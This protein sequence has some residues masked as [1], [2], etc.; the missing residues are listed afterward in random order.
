MHPIEQKEGG[1][2]NHMA[3]CTLAIVRKSI[4]RP[5]T[6]AIDS[7]VE[8]TYALVGGEGKR[9]IQHA[10]HIHSSSRGSTCNKNSK[11]PTMRLTSDRRDERISITTL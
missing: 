7:L 8:F 3:I 10:E 6:T 4:R 9:E 1:N 11:G 2:G 5:A